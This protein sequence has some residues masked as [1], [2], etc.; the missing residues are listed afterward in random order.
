MTTKIDAYSSRRGKW[1][2]HHH[3]AESS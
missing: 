3:L 2:K 1:S